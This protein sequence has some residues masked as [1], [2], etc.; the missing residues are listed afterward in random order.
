MLRS[1]YSYFLILI[2]LVY[3]IGSVIYKFILSKKI[4]SEK[5]QNKNKYINSVFNINIAMGIFFMYL[6][7][8]TVN[9]FLLGLTLTKLLVAPIVAA[10]SIYV[11]N[12]DKKYGPYKKK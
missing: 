9:D 12:L 3:I 8:T 10:Y 7:V 2:G 5:F 1:I 6:G 4:P 11:L